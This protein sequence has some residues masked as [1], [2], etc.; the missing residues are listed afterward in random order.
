MAA[1]SGGGC[2]KSA[3]FGT[4][5]FVRW[6]RWQSADLSCPV[7]GPANRTLASDLDAIENAADVASLQT[8]RL[9]RIPNEPRRAEAPAPTATP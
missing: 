3:S 8:G 7:T 4:R 2:M 5:T 1:L 6:H 9:I